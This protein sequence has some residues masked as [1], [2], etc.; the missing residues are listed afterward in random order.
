MNGETLVLRPI[1]HIRS[2][3]TEKFGIPR[4]SGLVEEVS[5]QVVLRRFRAPEAFGGWR[6]FPPLAAVGIFPDGGPGLV[7]DSAA[8]PA[9]G[10]Q[11]MGVFATR[12]PFRPNPIGLS[13]VRL[14]RVELHT[15]QGPVLWVRGAD[16]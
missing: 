14:E 6:A 13:C 9:G 7:A 12:S 2:P 4:Q 15:S 5:A 10:N 11:R 8:R 16:L 3:F 1:A